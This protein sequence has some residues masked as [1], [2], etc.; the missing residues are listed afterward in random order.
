MWKLLIIL[1]YSHTL[2]LVRSNGYRRPTRPPHVSYGFKLFLFTFVF[3][4][5]VGLV[6]IP[7]VI[8]NTLEIRV[9]AGSD[10]AEERNPTDISLTSSDLELTIDTSVNQMVGMRFNGITIP[11]G[12][13]ITNAYIQFQ[14]DETSNTTTNLTIQGQSIDNAPTFTNSNGNISNRTLTGSAVP[15]SPSDWTSVGD[16]GLAQRTPD[17]ALVIQEIVGLTGWANG[18]SMVII[19]TGA[20]RRVAESYNGQAGAA[21]LLHVEYT[22]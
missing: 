15:W 7:T 12:A 10:D 22:P 18:N 21:P 6:A 3:V 4:S 14:V 17:I 5:L 16:A 9:S 1:L 2:C 8:G 20:G 13:T 19:I 11:P